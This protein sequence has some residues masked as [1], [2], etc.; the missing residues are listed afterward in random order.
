VVD[1]QQG[2][3]FSGDDIGGQFRV[4]YFLND[5][6]ALRLGLGFGTASYKFDNGE[7]GSNLEKGTESTTFFAIL[8]EFVY[9]FHGTAR[10]APYVGAGIAFGSA[11]NKSVDED[12]DV[13]VTVKNTGDMFNTFGFNVFTEFNYFI[14]E[15]LYLGVEAGIGFSTMNFKHSEITVEGVPGWTAP[16]PSKHKESISTFGFKVNPILRLGWVF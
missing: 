14:A 13:K 1:L 10:L 16:E 11:S 7:T 12:G 2:I 5:N 15:N 6:M 8:P 9:S 4:S 3:D